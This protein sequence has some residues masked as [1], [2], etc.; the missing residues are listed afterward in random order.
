M[1]S[2]DRPHRSRPPPDDDE[3]AQ[4]RREALSTSESGS[5]NSLVVGLDCRSMNLYRF[6]RVRFPGQPHGVIRGWIAAG[7]V[8]V[9]G[10]AVI[11]G[12]PLRFGDVVD[13]DG[14]VRSRKRPRAAGE[15][16]ELH[17]DAAMFAVDKPAGLA[18]AAERSIRQPDLLTLLKRAAPDA[19]VKL[20]HRI[21]KHASGVVVFALGRAAKTA[22]TAEFAARRVVKDYLAL[23]SGQVDE[24]VQVID[25]PLTPSHGKV[26]KMI[27]VP[28]RGKPAVTLVRALVRFR[29]YSLV[30]AR[31]LTG[32]TH[33]IRAHLRHLGHALL[34][35][36]AYDGEES[37]LLSRLKH[38]YRPAR[39]ESERPLLARLALHAARIRLRSPADG[40]DVTIRAPLPRDLRAAI[41]QL[42]KAAALRTAPGLDA[43]LD[44][45]FGPDD[46][47]DPFAA[48]MPAAL[49]RLPGA[50]EDVAAEETPP[51]AADDNSP[52]PD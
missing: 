51:D 38:G 49:A 36:A 19:H 28:G 50:P 32:R 11:D 24:A 35:D 39:G 45:P 14:D 9:N 34:C 22:L 27:V 41:K 5:P 33:Q 12:R 25:A 13:I 40:S 52:R 46:E 15:L 42:Q 47:G 18:T 8:A 6:L 16:V 7:K 30:H 48:A 2:R 23:V 26:Q 1:A 44:A 3:I 17:R 4:S 20:V 29:G 37:L 21:D 43:L 10:T 31:P